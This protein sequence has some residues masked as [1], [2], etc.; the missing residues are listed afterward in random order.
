VNIQSGRNSNLNV[1]SPSNISVGV[2]QY[3]KNNNGTFISEKKRQE[4]MYIKEAN[5]QVSRQSPRYD[6]EEE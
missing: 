2:K 1:K 6:C 4:A 3:T 5:S